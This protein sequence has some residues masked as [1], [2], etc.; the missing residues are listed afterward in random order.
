METF[1]GLLKIKRLD[2]KFLVF[3]TKKSFIPNI[4]I[5]NILTNIEKQ[6]TVDNLNRN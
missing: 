3:P 2:F 6:K 5:P 4:W 1:R